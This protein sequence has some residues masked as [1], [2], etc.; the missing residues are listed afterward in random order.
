MAGERREKNKNI[1]GRWTEKLQN[2][3]VKKKTAGD[4]EEKESMVKIN[5]VQWKTGHE[6]EE[7]KN[8][9]SRLCDKLKE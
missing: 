6:K 7:E 8:P 2:L 5:R 4:E 9:N 1:I 3:N